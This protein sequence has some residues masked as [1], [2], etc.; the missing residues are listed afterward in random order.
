MPA[1]N[2]F[3]LR[4]WPMVVGSFEIGKLRVQTGATS[5]RATLTSL[6]QKGN[7]AHAG[8][9]DAGRIQKFAA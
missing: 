4:C 1:K 5:L 2:R 3:F 9:Q 6:S 7:I 8:R